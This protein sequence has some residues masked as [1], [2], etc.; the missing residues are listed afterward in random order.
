MVQQKEGPWTW[1]SLLC[2]MWRSAKV[3]DVV[4][5]MGASA[6]L[7]VLVLVLMRAGHLGRYRG[8]GI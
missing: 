4:T 7:C 2:Q 1:R 6:V 8:S 5:G 3:L